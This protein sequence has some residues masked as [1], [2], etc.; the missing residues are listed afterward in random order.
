MARLYLPA[1]RK[2]K[3]RST[4]TTDLRKAERV[5]ARWKAELY[6]GTW[7]PNVDK[8]TFELVDSGGGRLVGWDGIEPPTPGFSDRGLD[9][10]HCLPFQQLVVAGASGYRCNT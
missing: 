8:A 5:L 2:H 7:L 9:R 1:L 6:G 10:L 4:G 3:Q